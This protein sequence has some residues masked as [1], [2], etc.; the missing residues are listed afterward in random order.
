MLRRDPRRSDVKRS[1]QTRKATMRRSRFLQRSGLAAALLLAVTVTLEA[2]SPTLA[3]T[4]TTRRMSVSSVGVEGND[5]TYDAAVS[6]DGR[7]VAFRSQASNLVGSDTNAATDVFVRDRKNHTI[8]RVSVSSAGAEGNGPS[9]DA[10]ISADGR[11]VA[12]DSLASNLIATDTNSTY[13]VFVYD[14]RTDTTRRVSVSSAGGEGDGSSAEPSISAGGRFVAFS[15]FA[16]NLVGNDTN[17][18]TD[19]FVHDRKTHTTKRASASS[20]G[21]EGNSGSGGTSISADGR[22][23]AFE[24]NSSNLVGN[25]TNGVMDIFVRDRM[26]NTTRRVSVSSAG[27]EANAMGGHATIS[28]DGRF[29]AFE[30]QASNLV[31]NDTNSDNDIFVRDRKNHTTKRV[32]VN[33]AGTAANDDSQEASIS[34]DGR[35]V[36]F[37]SDATNLVGNDTNAQPDVF[38]R[39]RKSHTTRRVSVS[40]AGTEANGLSGNPSVSA[41]GRFVAFHSAATN[42]VGNDTNA[43]YDI[44]IRGPLS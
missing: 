4:A 21:V 25:D 9:Y 28:A 15:S 26:N 24:S 14:R 31:G 38:V 32:S 19:I 34:A 16:T 33:S 12:F 44:F 7:F 35:Y 13:D 29:V 37:G 20:A 10:S 3:A 22:F 43:K 40:S 18:A 5:G 41:D 42:L 1:P 2:T 17:L 23:V 30:S 8:E 39:D 27:V 36:S 6:A 11:F